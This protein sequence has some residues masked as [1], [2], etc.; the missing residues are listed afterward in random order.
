[1]KESLLTMRDRPSKNQTVRSGLLHLF[2]WVVVT[3]FS[4]NNFSLILRKLLDLKKTVSF[5]F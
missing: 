4:E 1:M 2:E 3:L 5:S